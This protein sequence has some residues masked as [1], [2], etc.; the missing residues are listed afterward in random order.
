MKPKLKHARISAD[1]AKFMICRDI[2]KC[3]L[4]FK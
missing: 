3:A 2:Y 1:A 4:L